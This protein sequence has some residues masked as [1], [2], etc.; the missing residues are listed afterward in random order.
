[1]GK[2]IGKTVAITVVAFIGAL[3]I[4]FGVL[5]LFCPGTLANFFGALGGYSAS[6]YFK[7]KEYAK[8]GE[9][10]DLAELVI[11]LDEDKDAG[12][13]AKY[14]KMLIDENL[15]EFNV[16]CSEEGKK[17]F[18]S[19]SAAKEFFYD[20]Y[21]VAEIN[22]GDITAAIDV[23][24]NCVKICGYTAS[25]PFRTFIYEKADELNV[26]ELNAVK[27][28]LNDL[29]DNYGSGSVTYNA[30]VTDIENLNTIIGER[31]NGQNN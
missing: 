25:N 6:V 16:Y 13:T 12:K 17:G 7:E 5:A 11:M 20:K 24:A 14:C 31:N 8:T 9:V 26:T 18:G 3:A 1:M 22:T 19:V 29:K 21:A 10:S 15:S 4:T 27:E 2:L 28:K 23:A 30:V